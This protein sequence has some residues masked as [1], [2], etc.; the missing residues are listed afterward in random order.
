MLRKRNSHIYDRAEDDWYLEPHW[1]SER[2]FAVESF[3]RD[4]AILDPCCGT[5]RVADA[6]KAAG[7]R[8]LATDIVDRGYPDCRVQDF[9]KRKSAPASIAGNP[10][11]DS[12]EAFAR[13]ALAIDADKV[14]L[15]FPVPRLNAAH[16]LRELPLCRI[17]LLTPRPSMPAG[18]YVLAGGKVGG[19]RRDFCWIIFERGYRGEPVIRWLHR[20]QRQSQISSFAVG[21]RREKRPARPCKGRPATNDRV[22]KEN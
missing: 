2:L 4:S 21:D 13:H 19:D 5:G 6:A 10:P 9:L 8:V 17:W 22:L 20:D 14:A 1:V 16:W 12:V 3:D 18:S 15:I 7:Y 11:F